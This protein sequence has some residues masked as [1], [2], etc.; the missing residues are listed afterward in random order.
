MDES[1]L[2]LT[3]ETWAVMEAV[4]A[5]RKSRAGKPP[6]LSDREFVEA[7]LYLARVACPWRD[8]PKRFGKWD[9]VYNRFRRWEELGVWEALFRE[10]PAD[11]TAIV[12]VFFDSTVIRAHPHAAGAPA[13]KG[14]KPNRPSVA[15]GAVSARK[16]TSR[17]LMRPLRSHLC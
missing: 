1:R 17:R 10:L 2:M 12:K 4:I 11:V 3:D 7:M 16:S 9:A 13:K 6:K 14:G 8:L 5:S 15:A